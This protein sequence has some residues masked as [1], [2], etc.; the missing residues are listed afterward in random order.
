MLWVDKNHPE[1]KTGL[2]YKIEQVVNCPNCNRET[3][4]VYKD[5]CK[6]K[7]RVACCQRCANR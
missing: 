7:L 6:N 5:P 3:N 2:R 4:L 1:Y